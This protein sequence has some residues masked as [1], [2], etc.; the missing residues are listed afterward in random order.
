MYNGYIIPREHV[1]N[2]PVLTWMLKFR[3]TPNHF[4]RVSALSCL[5]F[6]RVFAQL[7]YIL[8][9]KK[10]L[11]QRFTTSLQTAELYFLDLLWLF[12]LLKMNSYRVY[13]VYPEVFS[14]LK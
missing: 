13:F 2:V 11:L 7:M 9:S 10:F 14:E 5:S 4:S 12:T 8:L 6:I 1:D 3:V